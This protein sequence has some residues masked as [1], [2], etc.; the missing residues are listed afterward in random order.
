MVTIGMLGRDDSVTNDVARACAHVALTEHANFFWFHPTSV[1]RKNKTIRAKIWHRGDWR[2][3]SVPYPDVVYDRLRLKNMHQSVQP[4]YDALEGVPFMN[5]RDG[6]P[7]DKLTLY[8]KMICEEHLHK[9]VIPFRKLESYTTVLQWISRWGAVILKPSVGRFGAGVLFIEQKELNTYC[10][11]ERGAMSVVNQNELANLI[12]SLIPKGYILQK[13]IKL[14]TKSGAPCDIRV[15][16]MK[17]NLHEWSI[18]KM[19]PRIGIHHAVISSTMEG[20]YIGGLEGFIKTNFPQLDFATINKKIGNFSIDIAE[21][22]ELTLNERIHEV[23]LDIALSDN[24]E[25]FLIELNANQPGIFFYE[26]DVALNAIRYAIALAEE[27]AKIAKVS[28][29]EYRNIQ[30]CAE[31]HSQMHARFV[32]AMNEKSAELGMNNSYFIE[33]SGYN[34]DSKHKMTPLDALYMMIAASKYKDIVEIWPVKKYSFTVDGSNPREIR[35]DSTVVSPLIEN[36]Y[37][38]VGGKT[39]TITKFPSVSGHHLSLIVKNSDREYVAVVRGAP[40]KQKCWDDMR[41][42]LDSTIK[43]DCGSNIVLQEIS[44]DGAAVALVPKNAP[45]YNANDSL[46]ILNAKNLEL[47]GHPASLTKIMTAMVF[48]DYIDDLNESVKILTPD[49]MKG[50]GPVFLEGDIVSLRD[51]LYSLLLPSSNTSARLISRIIGEILLNNPN[52]VG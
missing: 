22:F 1:N 51:I 16:L 12:F 15:H 36:N 19:Y 34:G 41:V 9:H 23:G 38:I 46:E 8:N 20:G 32:I 42:L 10:V 4:V 30:K 49:L 13:Y 7:I 40:S 39:G 17:H 18:V 29:I 28:P 44:A 26:F 31:S 37:V 45:E 48:L 11:H 6:L 24:G 43:A 52:K 25:I 47:P 27:N 33:P 5:E 3:K 14:R 35:V 2:I 50:S 21:A